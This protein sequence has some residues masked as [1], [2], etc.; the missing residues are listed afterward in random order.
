MP[1]HI[2]RV[3]WDWLPVESWIKFEVPAEANNQYLVSKRRTLAN[4]RSDVMGICQVPCRGEKA[5]KV[6]SS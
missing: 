1:K 3:N 2:Y 5:L 6:G 4:I